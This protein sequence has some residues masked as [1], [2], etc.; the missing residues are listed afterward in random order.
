MRNTKRTGKRARKS[1]INKFLK[2][3]TRDLM[4]ER[5]VPVIPNLD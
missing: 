3:P 5:A 2:R 1:I 4:Q